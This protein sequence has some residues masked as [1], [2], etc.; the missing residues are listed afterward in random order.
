MIRELK[1]TDGQTMQPGTV[2]CVASNYAKHAS[3][4]GSQIPSAPSIFIKPPQAIIGNGEDI[5]IPEISENVHHEVELVVA[6]GKECKNVSRD[7][8]VEYIAGYAVGIDVTMRDVQS[9]AKKN[10]KPWAI[11]KGFATSA[12]LSEFIPASRFKGEVPEF[13]LL[14]SVNGERKQHGFTSEMERDV[15]TLIEFCS[16]IFTLVPGD[17]IFTGTPEGVG[18]IVSGDS[19]NAELSG[20]VSLSV[21]VK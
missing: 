5:V 4:M 7:V 14:L 18:K 12:P 9:A 2:F 11:A 17:L 21:N 15:N 13:E 6:I 1:F 10:G 20:F 16:R 8:A 19:I 3:E